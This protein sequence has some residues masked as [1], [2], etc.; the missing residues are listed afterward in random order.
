[1]KGFNFIFWGTGTFSILVLERLKE[2]GLLPTLIISTPDRPSGRH[3]EILPTPAKAWAEANKIEHYA[4]EKLRDP[5]TINFFKNIKNLENTVFLVASYG[6]IIPE[7]ILNLPKHK[8][9][10]IHPS[11]LPKLRGAS[12]IQS[13]LLEE[14]ETGVTIIR[15]DKEMDHGPIVSQKKVDFISWPL[16]YNEAEESLATIGGDM[17]ADIFEPWCTGKIQEKEQDHSLA[18]FTKKF[19]KSDAEV[20]PEDPEQ[21]ELNYRKYCAFKVWPE[22]FFF[23]NKIRVKIKHA[24]FKDNVFIIERVV[25]EGRKEMSYLDFLKG[26]L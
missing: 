1:M 24:T 21:A 3:Q 25:P 5:E 11:L 26:F 19:E 7:E 18:T 22:I 20:F 17:F 2:L 10:N 12:P 14:N 8:T 16:P 6:K 15:L 9:L 13:A 4:P 23:Y